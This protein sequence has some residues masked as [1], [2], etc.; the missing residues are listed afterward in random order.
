VNCSVAL[1]AMLGFEGVMEIELSDFVVVVV[2]EA[3][4]PVIDITKA[5]DIA[6]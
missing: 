5:I 3:P 6:K 2:V 1:T 4:Q